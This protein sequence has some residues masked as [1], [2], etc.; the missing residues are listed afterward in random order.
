MENINRRGSVSGASELAAVWAMVVMGLAA[1]AWP[2]EATAW[3]GQPLAYVT[4]SRA[5]SVSVIDTGDNTVV[6]TVHG[7]TGSNCFFVP[8]PLAVAPDGKHVYVTTCNGVSVIETVNK[9]DRLLKPIPLGNSPGAIAVAPDGKHVYV[10]PAFGPSPGGVVSVIETATNMVT[11]IS[12]DA[13]YV[14]PGGIAASPDGK[15]VY[16]R[17]WGV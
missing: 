11:T 15:R 3:T 9:T 16:F 7:L 14:Y 5:S 10:G 12:V 6:D 2:G 13:Q 17:D 8:G 4:N 1:M